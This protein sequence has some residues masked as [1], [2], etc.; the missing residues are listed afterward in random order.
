MADVVAA[1]G[2]RAGTLHVAVDGREVE[3][4]FVSDTMVSK[5][6]VEVEHG[7]LV[8]KSEDRVGGRRGDDDRSGRSGGSDEDGSGHSGR[9][10]GSDD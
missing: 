2:F 3:V 6:E 7:V 1:A 4:S 10:R 5:L 8:G 9:G